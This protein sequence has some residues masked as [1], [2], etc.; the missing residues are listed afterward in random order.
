MA[1][2]LVQ[3]GCSFLLSFGV[4]G[5]LAPSLRAGDVVLAERIVADGQTLLSDLSWFNR[6]KDALAVEMPVTTGMLTGVAVAV[7]SAEEK[8]RLH[9]ETGGVALDMESHAVANA[10]QELGVPFLAV[11][12]IADGAGQ[13]IPL[14][15]PGAIDQAGKIN[16]AAFV[17]GF[18]KHPG[19][20]VEIFR[21]AKANRRAMRSL[22]R[23]AL[24]LGLGR[25][26]LL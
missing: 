20:G 3:Q 8:R 26:G 10:A 9:D 21:L 1:R 4:A 15:L 2:D 22:R 16:L 19:D 24:L 23:V 18:A 12:V 11:R 13:S 17:G 7:A 25:F 5:G 6:L 14:W